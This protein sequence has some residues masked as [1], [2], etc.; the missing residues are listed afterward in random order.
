MV[1]CAFSDCHKFIHRQSLKSHNNV[2]HKGMILQKCY[3]C[4][5]IYGKYSL[6]RHLKLCR[7]AISKG[8]FSAKKYFNSCHKHFFEKKEFEHCYTNSNQM[9]KTIPF[10][11]F[12][13]PKLGYAKSTPPIHRNVGSLRKKQQELLNGYDRSLRHK[14]QRELLNGYEQRKKH[15]ESFNFF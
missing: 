4:G 14:Y 3:Y 7:A 11:D 5:K 13:I 9:K 6:R 8:H 1:Q 15:T 12:K 10:V 2:F